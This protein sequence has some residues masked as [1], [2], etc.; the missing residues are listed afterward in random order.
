VRRSAEDELRRA[1]QR[2]W[3]ALLGGLVLVGVA[4]LVSLT[5]VVPD[6]TT[7]VATIVSVAGMIYAVATGTLIDLRGEPVG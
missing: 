6:L 2:S 4:L 1:S 5:S 3:I 7:T